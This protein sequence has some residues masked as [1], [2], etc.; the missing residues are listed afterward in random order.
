MKAHAEAARFFRHSS[1]II[2]TSALFVDTPGTRWR[3]NRS[4]PA[5]CAGTRSDRFETSQ[6]GRRCARV[7]NPRRPF[8]ATSEGPSKCESR[9]SNPDGL[10]HWILSPAR[11]PIPPLSQ[12]ARRS[13]SKFD[14]QT[15]FVNWWT[16]GLGRDSA[17][18]RLASRGAD[19]AELASAR[20]LRMVL[21][22]GFLT[23]D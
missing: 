22:A 10:P 20:W 17:V 21:A 19:A 5:G 9:E 12:S 8:S 3:K 23:S 11:L 18:G 13:S 7:L 4:R 15:S 14:G 2:Y 1:F 16:T 6:L